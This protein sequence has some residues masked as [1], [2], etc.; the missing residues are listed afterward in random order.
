MMGE[1]KRGDQKRATYLIQDPYDDDALQFIRTLFTYFGLRP[2]CF[3]TDRKG[4]VY[5]ERKYPELQGDRI[6]ARYDVDLADLPGFVREVKRRYNVLGVIPYR[7]DTIELAAKLCGLLGLDWNPAETVARFRDKHALKTFVKG[8]DPNVRVPACWLVHGLDDVLAHPLPPRFVLKPND[9]FGNRAI[10]MFTP[11]DDAAIAEHL[12]RW[13]GTTWV[14]EEYI[15][16]T[17][18]HI[19]GQV[20]AD[21]EVTLLGL[22]QYERAEANGYETVYLSERQCRT[23]HPEFER[24]GDYARRLMRATGLR[25]SPFHMEVKVDER[26][27]CVIDLGARFPSES[28]GHM[29]SR[30]HPDRPDVYAVAAHD[31]LGRTDFARTPIDWSHYDREMTVL[32]YGV[33]DSA[34]IIQ[35]VSGLGHVEALPEFVNWVV[36]PR[37]GDALA[38]TTDLRGAPYIVE[39]RHRG[40][41]ADSNAL[42]TR[43]RDAIRWNRRPGRWAGLRAFCLGLVRRI[44]GK[45]RWLTLVALGAR[46][47]PTMMSLT[48]TSVVYDPASRASLVPNTAPPARRSFC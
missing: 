25:R 41:D 44:P 38:A 39:L 23:S 13:P 12:A 14:L 29:L 10:G 22:L 46:R 48:R 36:K 42:I 32:V 3:Y 2:V 8:Q 7:E 11:H 34:G 35:D 4:R 19:N 26:G 43:V 24:I 5:G 17:E 40:S 1:A 31:Y 21:G 45:L 9:G 20:R 18:Y 37:V 6:E 30:F 15:G 33:S 16:G 28:G 27:P 47:K